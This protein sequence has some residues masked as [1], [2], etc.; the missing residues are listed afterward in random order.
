[1]FLGPLYRPV[2]DFVFMYCLSPLKA[3]IKHRSG[4]FVGIPW[5]LVAFFLRACN[6]FIVLRRTFYIQ[7]LNLQTACAAFNLKLEF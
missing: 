3:E 4:S 2:N 1:M 5:T 6:T 7:Y